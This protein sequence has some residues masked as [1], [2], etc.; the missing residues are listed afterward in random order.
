MDMQVRQLVHRL[1]LFHS[2]PGNKCS[3]YV[4]ENLPGYIDKVENWDDE[5]AVIRACLDCDDAFLS[6]F[7]AKLP[8]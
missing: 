2:L 1:S 8:S 4:A 3:P 7:V 6:E 5:K